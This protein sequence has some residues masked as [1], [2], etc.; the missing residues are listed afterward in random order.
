MFDSK[1]FRT[2]EILRDEW[3]E[4]VSPIR[5]TETMYISFAHRSNADQEEKFRV[6]FT[7]YPVDGSPKTM[8]IRNTGK[9]PA[10]KW[11]GEEARGM[12][13]YRFQIYG[14]AGV[15]KYDVTEVAFS[16]AD[17]ISALT[18]VLEDCLLFGFYYPVME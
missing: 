1:L 6:E 4:K 13:M 2:M 17:E 7:A 15:E 12:F 18:L 5:H 16:T 3:A 10:T 11:D 8:V 14:I 9:A